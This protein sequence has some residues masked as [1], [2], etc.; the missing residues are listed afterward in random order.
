MMI[1]K[2][3]S[4]EAKVLNP[5]KTGK[6]KK[7]TKKIKIS[8]KTPKPKK[9]IEPPQIEPHLPF[10][11]NAPQPN[12]PTKT[13]PKNFTF[14]IGTKYLIGGQLYTVRKSQVDSGIEWRIVYSDGN[15][16]ASMLNT[17]I[18]DAQRDRSFVLVEVPQK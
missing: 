5:I 15:E 14:P 11:K 8:T 12:L 18:R 4:K 3:V 7:K 16:S 13:L 2:I 9:A 1:K 10:I 6:S 17:L